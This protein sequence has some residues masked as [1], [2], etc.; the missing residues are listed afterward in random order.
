M[1]LANVTGKLNIV[2][3]KFYDSS[4]VQAGNV[5]QSNLLMFFFDCTYCDNCKYYTITY[6]QWNSTKVLLCE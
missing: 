3:T 2:V 5:C 6:A 4:V 1:R